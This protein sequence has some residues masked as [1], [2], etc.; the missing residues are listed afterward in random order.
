[1]K[2]IFL[3]AAAA[4]CLGVGAA[5]ADQG[6]DSGAIDPNSYFTELPGEVSTAPGA[7]PN[8]AP[9][10]AWQLM[11]QQSTSTTQAIPSGGSHSTTLNGG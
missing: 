11:G 1:M 7:R 4:L 6:E 5:H 9:A 3:A 2:T 8:D 10:N